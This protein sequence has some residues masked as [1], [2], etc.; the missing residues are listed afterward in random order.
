MIHEWANIVEGR[1]GFGG[2]NPLFVDGDGAD[3]QWGTFDDNCR[4]Q[5]QSPAINA[6]N[7]DNVPQDLGDVDQDGNTSE[8]LPLDFDGETRIRDVVVDLGAFEYQPETTGLLGD[9]NCDGTLTVSDI[10][11]FVLALTNPASYAAQFPN[12]EIDL[13]DINQ[14]GAVTVSDIGFFVNLLT[15]G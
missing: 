15:G 10:A 3:N 12:C 2:S 6:G 14:D 13:A 1:G 7:V 9:M 5:E 11:G 8:K 4:L